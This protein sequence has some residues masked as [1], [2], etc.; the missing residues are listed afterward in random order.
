[1]K[2]L[3]FLILLFFFP[4][5]IIESFANIEFEDITNTT[6]INYQGDSYGASWGDFND[7]GYPDLWT[8][9]H[10]IT[11]TLYLNNRDE[12]FSEIGKS[13]NF[14]KFSGMD[15]HGA[16][17]ADFDNDGD[18]DL[19]I[20]VGAV[21]GF[22]E[23]SNVFLINNENELKDEAE[24]WDLQYSLGRG[25]TPLWFDWNKDGLLDI[26][27]TNAVRS[28]NKSKTTIFQQQENNFVE[29]DEKYG[30]QVRDPVAFAQLS[31]LNGDRHLELI[32]LSWN[33]RG[34]YDF[35]DTNFVNIFDEL[36]MPELGHKDIAFADFG[37]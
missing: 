16:S 25:R 9:N 30:F 14:D 1:M 31:D 23:D 15:F 34:I 13:F 21:L 3:F 5:L 4:T 6:G 18:Q 26:A 7:D 29:V 20:Q 8:G 36:G 2:F 19:I 32:M 22:G 12:T 27:L 11:P 28:D 10:Y 37:V 35:K 24:I 33:A 17:W